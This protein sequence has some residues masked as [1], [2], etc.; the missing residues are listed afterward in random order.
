MKR[1]LFETIFVLAVFC[2]TYTVVANNVTLTSYAIALPEINGQAESGPGGNLFVDISSE[3]NAYVN[4]L[5][6]GDQIV[7][8]DDENRYSITVMRVV[9]DF[10]H[11]EEYVT[12]LISP[13]S[14]RVMLKEKE[15]TLVDFNND[16]RLD[17][18]VRVKSIAK[19][20]AILSFESP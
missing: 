13:G 18:L 3:T 16:G 10:Q 19:G 11:G 20:R 8:K 7:I 6:D 12:L 15:S 1:T 2:L 5:S 9:Q 14:K 17:A 4:G